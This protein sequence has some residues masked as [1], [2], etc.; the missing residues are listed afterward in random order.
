MAHAPA[1]MC[2]VSGPFVQDKRYMEQ[3]LQY[4][5]QVDA[6]NTW[7]QHQ[8]KLIVPPLTPT[9][10]ESQKMA[11]IMSEINTYVDEMFLKFIM[12]QEPLEKFADFVAQIERINIS[13]AL[14]FKP[15]WNA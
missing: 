7:S 13:E 10:E 11:A 8:G 4:P 9:P 3:Y 14:R 2:V 6:I 1:A 12:G 5:E 15:L